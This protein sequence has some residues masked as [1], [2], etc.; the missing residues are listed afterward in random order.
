M[1]YT[2]TVSSLNILII[3]TL[4]SFF[5][6]SKICV[7]SDSDACFVSSG[8]FFSFSLLLP[9]Q[10]FLLKVRHDACSTRNQGKQNFIVLVWLGLG[11]FN[12]CYHHRCQRLQFPLVSFF[13][14]PWSLSFSM[15]CFLNRVCVSQPVILEPCW[16]GGRC[17]DGDVFFNHMV[18]FGLSVGL[19]TGLWIRRSGEG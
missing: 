16:C 5:D 2:F 9:L 14:F 1:L 11:L 17:G 7:I 8:T 19:C 13:L 15:N 10:L 6:N 3:V 4:N 12:V 18:T